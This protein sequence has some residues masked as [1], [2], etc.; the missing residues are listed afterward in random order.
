MWEEQGLPK[1]KN[2][3]FICAWY[4]VDFQINVYVEIPSASEKDISDSMA[5]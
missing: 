5:N 1:S 2:E 3:T 4:L